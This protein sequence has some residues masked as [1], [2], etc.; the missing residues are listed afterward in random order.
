MSKRTRQDSS[1]DCHRSSSPVDESSLPPGKYAQL[2]HST[3]PDA[4]T[5]I[6]CMLP[7][8][9]PVNFSTYHDYEAHYHK[10]HVNR[11]LDCGKNFPTDHFLSLHIAERHDAINL[12]KRDRG[13][14]I[15]RCFVEDCD[16]VCRTPH[17]RR[18]HLVDKHMFPQDFDFYIVNHGSDNRTSLLLGNTKAHAKKQNATASQ[19]AVTKNTA[20]DADGLHVMNSS[21][22][23]DRDVSMDVVVESMAALRFVPKSV[24]FGRSRQ[25]G[26]F[27]ET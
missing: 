25:R 7:P 9:D 26:G 14:K 15:Y 24:T 12:V 4:S 5:F 23:G 22:G 21:Q 18:M 20:E 1:D 27:S 2:D 11:C 8:H 3:A 10:T 17:K 19:K 6:T 13:D 16:K